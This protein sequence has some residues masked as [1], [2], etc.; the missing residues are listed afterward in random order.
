MSMEL[1]TLTNTPNKSD[2]EIRKLQMTGGSTYIIS[3]PKKWVIQNQLDKGSSLLIREEEDGSLSILPP[4]FGKQEKSEAFIKVSPKDNPNA[5][6]MKTVSAY[7]VGY[8]VIY[9]RAEN[10]QNLSSRQRSILKTFARQLL[11][12]TEIVTDTPTE[13]TLQVLLSYPELSVESALRRMCIITSSMHKDAITALKELDYQ[14]A[15]DVIATD[16]EVDRF[17]LYIIRQLKMAVQNPR[18]IKGIGLSNAR[19]CLGYRLITKTVERT[20]DHAVNI[21]ENVLLL[22]K[23]IDSI[24]FEKIEK[25]STLSI[26]MF[27]TAIESLFRKDFNLAESVIEKTKEV[28]SMEKEAMLS[29]QKVGIE[30]VV[31]LRLLIESVRRTAEY[32]TDIAEIVLNMNVGQ[33]ITSR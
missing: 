17:H 15:R 5:T 21:A 13:L 6:I 23:R 10:Q 9:I 14:F 24:T 22:K 4:E 1:S 11:V 30:E 26:F 2:E 28:I 25:M 29:Y 33:V 19:D 27:E 20:A 7:L 18:I 12:G 16:N 31:S 32:A 8:N 3:L